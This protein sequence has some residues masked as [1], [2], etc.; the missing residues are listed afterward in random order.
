MNVVLIGMPGC[1]KSTVAS[2]LAKQLNREMVDAD[3]E[4][5]MRAGKTIPE[6]FAED[7]EEIFRQLE[8]QVLEDLGK[9]SGLIIATGGGCVTKQRNYRLLHQNSTIFWL[10]RNLE[11]LPTDGRPLS[12]SNKLEDMY[13]VRQPMYEAFAD[14]IVDNNTSLSNTIATIT[15]H[16]EG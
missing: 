1:G 9:Q 13:K 12:Q 5:E 14:C 16:L 10:K 2:L 3:A 7:G 11:L 4:I 6:I 8:T 15:E